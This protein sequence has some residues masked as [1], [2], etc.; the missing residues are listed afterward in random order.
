MTFPVSISGILE[1][2]EG[3]MWLGSSIGLLKLDRE[4]KRLIRYHN[5]PSDNESL[6]SDNVISLYQDNEGNIW[7]CF[8]GTEP[9]YFT[10]RPQAFQNFTYQQGSL[11]DP[12]VTSIYEDHNGILWIGSMGGL[13][14]IDR[15]TGK[16]FVP[17]GTG[18]GSEILSIL[19]DRS[20]ALLSGTFHQG[21][22]RLDRDTGK[23]SPYVHSQERSNLDR[24]PI[25]RLI[26]DHEGTLWAATYGGISRFDRSSGNFI[27]YTPEKENT[28]QYQEIK[29]DARGKLWLGAQSGLHRFDPQTGQFTVYAHD[30]EDSRSLS[31]NRVNSVHFDHSGDLWVGTQNGLD[32]FDPTTGTFK[33][34]NEQDGLAGDVVSCI[35]EDDRGA[36][37]MSTNNGLSSFDPHSRRFQNFSAA[38]GLPGSDLTG[39]GACY[40][41]PSGEMFFGG[42]SGATAFY[43]GRMVNS[44]FVPRTVLTD[45][46]LSGNPVPIG[47]GSPLT[48]SITYTD[49][50]S[51]SHQ[52]NIFSI[53]F[54]ALSYFNAETNRYRYKLEGL[55][56]RWHEVGSDQRIAGYTTL[57]TGTYIFSCGGRNKP[58]EL[59]RTG[60]NTSHCDRARLVSDILV[61]QHLC[62]A[63]PRGFVV[64]LPAP[65]YAAAPAVPCCAGGARR[66]THSN[67]ARVARHFAAKLQRA[68][69]AFSGC[70]ELASG[71]PGGGQTANR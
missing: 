23:L 5:H 2:R 62:D 63:V 20:G 16:N 50:I 48:Q 70:I 14:R 57:P 69:A 12:L 64:G 53:E 27:T 29:E 13:N 52:Q 10:E 22:Q 30:P 34:Y 36:L 43:P 17:P 3:T 65:C 58:W 38:D 7:T 28:I 6:E 42:F 61:P 56:D 4:H 41:S 33:T 68:S 66:R 19:E 67:R 51:L 35:L 15:H 37:W 1:S 46:R 60:R 31:D 18:V 21:L 71:A 44:S 8:Q 39:W 11:A 26:F 59:E 49:A 40:R 45:F 55:D 24:N 25:M 54:S 47:S 9:N 32:R